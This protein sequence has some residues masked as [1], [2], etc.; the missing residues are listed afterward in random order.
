[1]IYFDYAANTPVD[2]EV[3]KEFCEQSLTYYGNPN[4]SHDF[5]VKAKGRMDEITGRIAELLHVK[6]E[7]IIYTSGASEANNHAIKGTAYTYRNKGKHIISTCLEHFSVSGALTA[8]QNQGYEIDLVDINENGQVDLEHLQELLR[9][10]TI[11][12]SV[13]YVDS[14]LGVLQPISEIAAIVKDHN[15]FLHVDATQ[16]VGKLAITT[17]GIDLLSFAP[18]KF[19]GIGG[20]GILV[21]K[22]HVI[23]EPLIHGG[24]STTIYR[25]GTPALGLAASILKALEKA[26]EDLEMKY[27]YV[28]SLQHSLTDRL[29][30][31]PKVRINSTLRSI[32]YILN[33]SVAGIKGNDFQKELAKRGVCVSVKSACSAPG[34]PSRPVFAVTRDKKNAMHSWRISLSH[35]TTQAE[36]EEFMI[37]F[38]QCYQILLIG[39][40]S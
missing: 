37:A 12:V 34:T 11:L 4:S 40:N 26:E 30:Q 22:S 2:E 35:L 32:P 23:L 15:C 31:Y 18:H 19:Y 24:A 14:E 8:L 38:D 33:L 16:A 27:E 1:M 28:Q 6:D 39:D 21:R 5:G 29:K 17:K 13:C 25:S 20:C 9:K 36:I 10:D 3:L 7:E